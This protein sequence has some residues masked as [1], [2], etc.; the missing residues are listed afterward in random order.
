LPLCV[1]DVDD[2]RLLHDTLLSS[3]VPHY[4]L[5]LLL[6]ITLLLPL[7]IFI[8]SADLPSVNVHTSRM[9]IDWASAS[10][11]GAIVRVSRMFDL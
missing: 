3:N 1:L 6:L 7:P 9:F 10:I 5:V 8:F 4:Q 11:V 2:E